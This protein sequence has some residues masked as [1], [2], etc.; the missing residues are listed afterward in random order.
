VSDSFFERREEKR[1][2]EREPK[3]NSRE[4]KKGKRKKEREKTTACVPRVEQIFSLLK[5]IVVHYT[6]ANT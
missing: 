4:K 1:E 3:K 6:L 5:R 2:R